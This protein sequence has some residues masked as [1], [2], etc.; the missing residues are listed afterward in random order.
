MKRIE[1]LLFTAS[2]LEAVPGRH[3]E[4]RLEAEVLL[5]HCLG[6]DRV[7]LYMEPHARLESE[8]ES[9]LRRCLN[10]RLNLEPVSYIL[11]CREFFG[12]EFLVDPSVLI[13]RPESE[14]LVEK[15]LDHVRNRCGNAEASPVIADVG[16][17][18]GCLAVALAKHLPQSSVLAI[19]ISPQALKTA[20]RNVRAHGLAGRIDLVRGDLLSTC[21]IPGLDV[22][23]ANLPYV[24]SREFER[25]RRDELKYEPAL[26]L[27]GGADGLSHIRRILGQVSGKL[28]TESCLFLEVG[29]CQA[30]AVADMARLLVGAS[31][32]I[33]KDLGGV[34]RVVKISRKA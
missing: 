15:V 3:P 1:A 34:E 13:P 6:L 19:D 26:A 2:E 33:F 8:E 25:L 31:V 23:V 4:S 28:N 7:R 16:T 17:G 18:S 30:S 5:Q 12:L 20:R 27:D 14:L 24:P 22:I 32:E 11:G 29:M 21:R 9:R 10:R